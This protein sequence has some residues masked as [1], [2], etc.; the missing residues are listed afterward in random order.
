MDAFFSVGFFFFCCPP[1][2]AFTDYLKGLSP[3]TLDVELR[4]LQIIDD[5]D[6]QRPEERAE[7]HAIAL[8]LDYFIDEISSKNSFEFIQA[9]MRLFLKVRRLP[10]LDLD[11]FFDAGEEN[12]ADLTSPH[13]VR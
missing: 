3:S 1:D 11:F 6:I 8:L 7:L 10:P 12:A 2:L 9:V 5:E 13:I 4:M